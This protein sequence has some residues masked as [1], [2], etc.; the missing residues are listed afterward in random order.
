[1]SSLT[2]FLEIKTKQQITWI[3]SLKSLF[4]WQKFGFP[5]LFPYKKI[6]RY[7][8]GGYA[9][10]VWPIVRVTCFGSSEPSL[11]LYS[12][13][14][15]KLNFK[16]KCT[17]MRACLFSLSKY[18]SKIGLHTVNDSRLFNT[19]IP[20]CISLRDSIPSF[21]FLCLKPL[22]FA[23]T[24]VFS[25]STPLKQFTLCRAN[26][27]SS[28]PIRSFAIFRVPFLISSFVSLTLL[29][30][31]FFLVFSNL[32]VSPTYAAVYSSLTNNQRWNTLFHSFIAI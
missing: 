13:V 2:H 6:S 14:L 20:R 32:H 4:L 31:S 26:P 22:S 18:L 10:A 16:L 15:R 29:S 17:R 21:T 1:M 3:V 12:L 30:C 7:W 25:Q 11:Y 27:P 9:C 5:N 8:L 19:F 28:F 23:T 24:L